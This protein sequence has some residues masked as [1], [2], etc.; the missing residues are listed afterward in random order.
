VSPKRAIGTLLNT[1]RLKHPVLKP[2]CSYSNVNR[3]ST[4]LSLVFIVKRKIADS[5]TNDRYANIV[6]GDVSRIEIRV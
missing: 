6:L 1:N 2:K 5:K 3:Y 4:L